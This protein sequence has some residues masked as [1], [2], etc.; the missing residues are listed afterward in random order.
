MP[1]QPPAD[2]TRRDA[3]LEAPS[4]PAPPAPTPAADADERLSRAL[5]AAGAGLWDWDIPTGHLDWTP[6]LFRLF[7][8]DPATDA[9]TFA[10]W[11]QV[12]HPD[13]TT[14]AGDRIEEAL[15]SRIPLD[16]TYRVV[17]PDGEIRWVQALGN[18]TYD[19]DGQPLRMAGI[20]IDI[21]ARRRAEL[22]L[23]AA[24]TFARQVIGSAREGIIVYGPDGRYR[25]WNP[26]MEEMSGLRAADVIGRQPTELF[27]G[28]E[29][30]GVMDSVR[31]ALAGELPEPREIPIVVPG[32]SGWVIDTNAPLRDEHGAIVGVIAT[33]QDVT[34]RRRAEEASE[35]S[36]RLVIESQRAAG[37]GSYRADLVAGRWWSSEVLDELF[38]ID[39][40]FDRTIEA[41][42]DLI[43]PDDREAM[44]RYLG[45]EVIGRGSPFNREYRIVRGSDGAVRWV[46]GR[47]EVKLAPDGTALTLIGTIMDVTARHHADE[48]RARLESHLQQAQRLESIGRLAGGVAH[49]FNNML[50]AILGYTE[51]ALGR[52]AP[53]D[54]L[55]SDLEEIQRA[56]LRSAELTR[57]LL[58]Y[59]RRQPTAP[60]II[61]LDDAVERQLKMLRRLIGEDIELEW[62][63]DPDAGWVTIDPSEIDRILVNLCINARDAIEQAGRIVIETGWT[64][65]DA[66]ASAMR[67]G[68][69]PAEYTWLAVTDNGR[70]MSPATVANIFEPF[71]TTK[72]VGEGTGLGLAM[73]DGIVS[74]AGGFIDVTSEPGI[75]STFRVHLR[76][77][78][79]PV[80]LLEA[81]VPGPITPA[82]GAT[83]LVVEDEPALLAMA[84][85]ILER[86]GYAVLTASSP[87]AALEQGEVNGTGIDLLL[88]DVVMPGMSGPD[89]ARRMQVHCPTLRCVYMSGYPA[90]HISHGG[91]IADGVAFIEK[92]FTVEALATGIQAALAGE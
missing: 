40:A 2:T 48:D 14:A 43:H 79:Q 54:E 42:V 20:C 16:N 87:A 71:Y 34:D 82:G 70:G 64:R 51:L 65:L 60:R 90:D 63:P 91:V 11:R 41:W 74:R 32:R 46:N 8:L 21:T 30:A 5:R 78:A 77:Q 69:E 44:A 33:V 56:A 15:A 81:D 89:L 80:E 17:L 68:I 6:E 1:S 88:T 83:I 50:G 23:A 9:A 47:G 18:T 72:G 75:G 84:R 49:D 62:Q 67:P 66:R 4:R 76:R 36:A 53:D 29:G 38:G 58:T 52:V 39:E 55:R 59:A 86:L 35:E 25:V 7:G 31:R 57:Q 24:D 19:E 45:E 26:F 12:M 61:D 3:T 22:S 85:R 10:T 92:P 28:L 27:P 37:V 13:D 73:V